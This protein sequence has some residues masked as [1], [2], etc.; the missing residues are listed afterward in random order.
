MT[1]G[2]EIPYHSTL[3][4]RLA[5]QSRLPNGS[6]REVW[7]I[8]LA[9]PPSSKLVT[10]PH[11]NLREIAPGSWMLTVEVSA[12]SSDREAIEVLEAVFEAIVFVHDKWVVVSLFGQPLEAHAFAKRIIGL[13]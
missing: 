7:E 3:G 11:G 8:N 10:V 1:S 6:L 13:R 2:G 4:G 5:V 12:T 9:K